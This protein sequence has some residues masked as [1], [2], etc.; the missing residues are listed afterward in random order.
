MR[1]LTLEPLQKSKKLFQPSV[2]DAYLPATKLVGTHT[3]FNGRKIQA[4]IRELHKA[5]NSTTEAPRPIATGHKNRSKPPRYRAFNATNCFHFENRPIAS[6]GLK[7]NSGKSMKL[8]QAPTTLIP[9]RQ[10]GALDIHFNLSTRNGRVVVE[11]RRKS[12]L[13]AYYAN[14]IA[15]R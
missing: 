7:K 11:Y 5:S 4:P 14:L 3:S 12:R 8:S 2:T 1:S 10:M 9:P 15:L 6:E 13:P